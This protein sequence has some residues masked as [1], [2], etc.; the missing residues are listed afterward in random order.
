MAANILASGDLYWPL[1]AVA[2]EVQDWF[3]R[4]KEVPYGPPNYHLACWPDGS[5]QL[6]PAFL[7]LSHQVVAKAKSTAEKENDTIY[8]ERVPS[9][10]QLAKLPQKAMVKSLPPGD[11]TLKSDK[12]PFSSLVPFHILQSASVYNVQRPL[13]STPTT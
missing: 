4:F 11:L 8:H 1:R 6:N 9:Q 13:S 2:T 10:E 7:A 3:N 12:D 5:E